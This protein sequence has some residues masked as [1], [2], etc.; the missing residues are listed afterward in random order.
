MRMTGDVC[1]H[2]LQALGVAVCPVQLHLKVSSSVATGLA[3][4]LLCCLQV[5]LEAAD[6]PVDSLA[7]GLLCQLLLHCL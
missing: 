2:L 7:G 6:C 3:G 4:L 1:A 5:S